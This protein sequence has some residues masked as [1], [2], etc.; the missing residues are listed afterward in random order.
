MP[1]T[2]IDGKALAAATKAEAAERQEAEKQGHQPL[3]GGH[4]GGREPRQPGPSARSVRSAASE[5]PQ[6]QPARRHHAGRLLAEVKKL[7]DNSAMHG[8][9]VQLPLPAQIDEKAVIDAIPP[10]RTWTASRPSTWAVADRRAVPPALHPGGL[11]PHDRVRAPTCGQ[12]A[13]VNSRSNIREASPRR[14]CCWRRKCRSR[15]AIRTREPERSLR[16]RGYSRGRRG[17]RGFCERRH[18][19]TRCRRH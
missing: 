2:V 11:H 10:G 19:Q 17:P 5:K 8:I 7:T 15:S 18:G 3:P 6:H 4:S 9:L 13:V 16:R 1:A 12:N 14:C